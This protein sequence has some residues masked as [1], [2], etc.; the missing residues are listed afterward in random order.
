MLPV[1]WQA[2]ILLLLMAPFAMALRLSTAA[3]NAACDAVVDLI[4]GGSGAGL[5]NIYTGSQ[6]GSVGGSEGGNTL[7]G[8]LT[9]SDPAFGSASTGV[10]TASAITSD[11]TADNSGTAGH[12]TLTTSTPATIAD[13]TCGQGS[14]D[15]NFDNNVI[16]AGGTIAI[17]SMTVTQPI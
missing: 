1:F 14:G 15:I 7:L 16:V 12:A 2:F 6:V 4:D 9:F 10:A 17:S 3:R 13:C 5:I 8:T 11:T